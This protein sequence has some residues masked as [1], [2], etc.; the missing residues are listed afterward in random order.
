MSNTLISGHWSTRKSMGS[1]S[2]INYTN[3]SIYLKT[4]KI[5]IRWC[6]SKVVWSCLGQ[7]ERNCYNLCVIRAEDLGYLAL[8]GEGFSE[9]SSNFQPFKKSALCFPA[10]SCQGNI[11]VLF[12][13]FC[14]NVLCVLPYHF[15]HISSQQH[16]EEVR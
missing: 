15:F 4:K 1:A 3:I 14:V 6:A 10:N 7:G 16:S 5:N 8:K 11:N 9:N 12:K 2:V 13:Y